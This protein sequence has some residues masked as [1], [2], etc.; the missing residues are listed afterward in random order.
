MVPERKGDGN[1]TKDIKIHGE[2]HVVIGL[3]LKDRKT[4]GFDVYVGL[5]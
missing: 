3:Q 4:Y 5:R 1:L 2:I